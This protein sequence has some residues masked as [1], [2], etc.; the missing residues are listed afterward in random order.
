MNRQDGFQGG[1][2]QLTAFF[3]LSAMVVRDKFKRRS[4]GDTAVFLNGLAWPSNF[5]L[6]GDDI[7][8]STSPPSL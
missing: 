1:E 2:E 3:W 8:V 7:A 5:V 4:E 6:D